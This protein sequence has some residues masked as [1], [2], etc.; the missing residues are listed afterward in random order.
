M[1]A[2][3]KGEVDFLISHILKAFIE[4]LPIGLYRADVLD[5]GSGVSCL[6]FIHVRKGR[7]GAFDSRACYGF[8]CRVRPADEFG[9]AKQARHTVEPPNRPVRFRQCHL[10]FIA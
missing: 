1:N 8:A 3:N 5:V 10:C 6:G 4:R 7:L 2:L 9:I